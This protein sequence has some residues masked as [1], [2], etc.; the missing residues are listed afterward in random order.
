MWLKWYFWGAIAAGLITTATAL[1]RKRTSRTSARII[2][3]AVS[4]FAALAIFAAGY[5]AWWYT[6]RAKPLDREIFHGVRHMRVVLEEPRRVVVNL[7]FVDLKH[8]GLRLE[9]T[10]APTDIR[11]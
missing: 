10:P 5:L 4:I 6:G 1:F 9:V 11:P 3:A 2:G 7:I 8:R